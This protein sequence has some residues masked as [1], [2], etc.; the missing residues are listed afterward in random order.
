MLGRVV[1]FVPVGQF[2][3]ELFFC[4][5]FDTAT[6]LSYIYFRRCASLIFC[7]IFILVSQFEKGGYFLSCGALLTFVYLNLGRT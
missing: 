7:Y 4:F 2:E 1:V 5:L 3:K 6:V